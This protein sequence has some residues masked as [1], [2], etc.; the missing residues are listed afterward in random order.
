MGEGG[1]G[2]SF[3]SFVPGFNDF[4]LNEISQQK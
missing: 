4:N 1:G 3:L 2:F